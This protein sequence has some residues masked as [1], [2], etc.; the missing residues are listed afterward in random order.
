MPTF[1]VAARQ[2]QGIDVIIVPLD[3][4][5]GYKSESDK[6]AAILSLQ[7]GAHRAGLPGRIV[8]VWNDGRAM[9]FIAPP[10]WHPFFK[11][12]TWETVRLNINKR[13]TCG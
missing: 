12:L 4:S 10:N 3:R 11:S 5:F 8:P 1:D 2:V 9:N 13:F 6:Q 7:A